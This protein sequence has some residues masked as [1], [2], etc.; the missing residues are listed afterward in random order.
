MKPIRPSMRALDRFSDR[1]RM[2]TVA[3]LGIGTAMICLGASMITVGASAAPRIEPVPA[4]PDITVTLDALDPVVPVAKSTLT[5]QGTVTNDS[6]HT[7]NGV[8]INVTRSASQIT[9]RG[10]IGAIASG[11]TV[12]PMAGLQGGFQ[13]LTGQ[14]APRASRSWTYRIPMRDLGFSS[15]GVYSI[16]VTA[17][18]TSDASTKA[19]TNSFV[20]WFPDASSVKPTNVVWLY[21]LADWPAR[22]ANGVLSNDRTPIEI[23]PGGRLRNLLDSGLTGTNQ[24]TWVIDP[25]LM[26][27]VSHLTKGYS[28][29]QPGGSTTT[30]ANSPAAVEFLAQA[31][32]GLKEAPV[33]ALQYADPDVTAMTRARLTDDIVRATTMAPDELGTTLAIPVTGGFAWPPDGR[34]DRA[35]LDVLQNAGI[36]T[37]LLN[38]TA[39]PPDSDPGFTPSGSSVLRNQGGQMSA[40][41]ADQ[42]LTDALSAP[43][44]TNADATLAR[45]RFLAELGVITSQLPDQQRT[46]VA[47]PEIR[48]QPAASV[49]TQLLA[50]LRTAPWA[51]TVPL[52][53][54]IGAPSTVVRTF[55]APTA[56]AARRNELP[57][58][59]LQKVRAGETQLGVLASILDDPTDVTARFRSAFQ[60]SESAAWRGDAGA[61]ELLLGRVLAELSSQIA[62]VRIVAGGPVSFSS[63]SGKVPVTIAND[64]PRPVQVGVKLS[65]T[66]AVRLVAAPVSA[67]TIPANRKVIIEIPAQILGD[68]G[69]EASV[70]LTTPTGADYGLASKVRL[71][72]TAYASAAA[73]VVGIA[74][75]T[76]TT[77]I[78]F[79]A[80]RRRR[81]RALERAGPTVDSDD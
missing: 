36:K 47:A 6:E 53:A 77:M 54:A 3:A 40:L 78:A 16:Q 56:R 33:I 44:V 1:R 18:A 65:A 67:M 43:Q 10:A 80:V 55:R 8:N 75:I 4:P 63:S 7:L 60:R 11:K 38:E 57:P 42:E 35:T 62:T 76:L 50:A 73:W 34:P 46:V 49:V 12:P 31:R 59:Y 66:P 9:D 72:S 70:Q 15:S 51:R 14:L 17:T 27:T 64:F 81:T 29:L 68:G 61:G 30:I 23:S 22:D 52:S 48:W 74:F 45:Q 26:E 19:S 20:P 79:S 24:V 21:P 25:A 13:Q 71:R 39:M 32:S 28:V 5:L 58:D 37:I 2:L 69:L 41:I